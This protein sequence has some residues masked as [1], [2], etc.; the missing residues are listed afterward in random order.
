MTHIWL[1]NLLK[2]LGYIYFGCNHHHCSHQNM[3]TMLFDSVAAMKV[4]D[5]TRM[6][7][8]LSN[9]DRIIS[10]RKIKLIDEIDFGDTVW[11]VCCKEKEFLLL[12]SEW[13]LFGRWWNFI[14]CQW[15]FIDS[16][17]NNTVSLYVLPQTSTHTRNPLLAVRVA[18]SIDA[19]WNKY[20]F[21]GN[22]LIQYLSN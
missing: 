22:S 8:A 13:N 17:M 9:Q 19:A 20:Q 3:D 16:D 6:L 1:L 12:S 5:M 10:L 18:A 21:G 2:M 7:V 15:H 14:L 11:W 4:V